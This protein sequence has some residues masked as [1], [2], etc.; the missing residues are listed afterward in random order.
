MLKTLQLVI[1]SVCFVALVAGCGS[2]TRDAGQVDPNEAPPPDTTTNEEPVDMANGADG[3]PV[4]SESAPDA[5][6]VDP[7]SP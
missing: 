6:G 5:V 7:L 2:A 3:N 4:G 1:L